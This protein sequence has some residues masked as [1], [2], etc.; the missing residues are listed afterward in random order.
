VSLFSWSSPI[1]MLWPVSEPFWLSN[2]HQQRCHNTDISGSKILCKSSLWLI[3]A[4]IFEGKHYTTILTWFA[5]DVINWIKHI[6]NKSIINTT[7]NSEAEV[8]WDT[9]VHTVYSNGQYPTFCVKLV[10]ANT[11]NRTNNITFWA[12][13]TETIFRGT[14]FFYVTR[15]QEFHWVVS[16]HRKRKFLK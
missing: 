9:F 12:V 11:K 16:Y 3:I 10:S 8:A 4:S 2:I 5:T 6:S 14:H 7:P 13:Q 15:S 1:Q